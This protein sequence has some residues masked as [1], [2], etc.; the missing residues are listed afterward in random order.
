M[1]PFSS[2][3]LR[4]GSDSHSWLSSYEES[5]EDRTDNRKTH[6]LR[7]CRYSRIWMSDFGAESPP[8]M[9]FLLCSP[10]RLLPYQALIYHICLAQSRDANEFP[11]ASITKMRKIHPQARSRTSTPRQVWYRKVLFPHRSNG[12][13]AQHGTLM[14]VPLLSRVSHHRRT[15]SS[16][17]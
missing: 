1:E 7:L 17:Q 14:K 2:L 6:W 8:T 10:V 4:R 16:S 9:S 5:D 15:M 3:Y 13:A 12:Y 11:A